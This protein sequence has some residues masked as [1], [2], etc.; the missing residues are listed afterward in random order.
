MLNAVTRNDK[1]A[2]MC[3]FNGNTYYV[4]MLV[5]YAKGNYERA[6]QME[7][8]MLKERAYVELQD[9]PI[10][11]FADETDLALISRLP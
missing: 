3:R 5:F 1:L 6:F 2:R 9:N 7:E 4:G 11:V 8:S 10:H